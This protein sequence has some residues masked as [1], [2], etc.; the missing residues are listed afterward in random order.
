[1]FNV[2]IRYLGSLKFVPGFP[3]V[4]EAW[5][6]LW[7]FI[8]K[9]VLLDWMDEIEAEMRKLSGLHIGMHKYGGVQ[10][11]YAQKEVGH[12]H[13]NGL[14]DVRLSLKLKRELMQQG[15]IQNHHV[16][17]DAGWVSFYIKSE[18]DK[19]YALELLKWNYERLRNIFSAHFHQ[20]NVISNGSERSCSTAK[21]VLKKISCYHSE[22]HFYL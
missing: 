2:V 9:P 20:S 17:T 16:F 11:N 21:V 8:T 1:M 7:T 19:D 22:W 12:L 5:L 6:K 3:L 13:G 15:R 18:S 4:F 10:F 14:L